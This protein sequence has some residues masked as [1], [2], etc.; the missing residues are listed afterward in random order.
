MSK[1]KVLP[2]HVA[3]K[4]AAGEVVDRPVNVVKELVENALDAGAT[5]VK[6]EI[7]DGGI[8]LIRVSDN[9]RGIEPEDLPLAVMRFATSKINNYEDLFKINTYG[10]RGEALAAISSVSNFNIKSG[11]FE[12]SVDFGKVGEVTPS[13][14]YDGTI[15][16]VKNIF[17]KIPARYKFLKSPVSEQKEIVKY[18]KQIALLNP[19]KSFKLISNEKILLEFSCN[20]TL[21]SKGKKIFG[22]DELVEVNYEEDGLRI[23]GLISLPNVQKFRK[24]NIFIGVNKRVVKDNMIAQSILQAYHRKI[25]ENRYPVASINIEVLPDSVD[26]NIHPAKMF[27]RFYNSNRI[28]KSI[29]KA[30]VE[31]LDFSKNSIDEKIEYSKEEILQT[32]YH[33]VSEYE[34]KYAVDLTKLIQIESIDDFQSEVSYSV[35]NED[36]LKILGQLFNTV[37]VV[38]KGDEV[39]FIDQHIAHERILYEKLIKKDNPINSVILTEPFLLEC[40][41]DEI[42]FVSEN[43]DKLMNCGI[44][45][46]IFGEKILKI[47]ALPA[48]ILNKNIEEEIRSIITSSNLNG[49]NDFIE[50]IYLNISCK[51]AIKAG[52]RLLMDEMKKLV[53]ELFECENPYT[54]PHGRPIIFKLNKNELFKKFH[55]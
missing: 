38:E 52:E 11:N 48:E 55:R 23:N 54:C 30:V 18:V 10:F 45:V 46:E 17:A 50:P 24:D 1:I 36:D 33:G 5:E 51:C 53:S 47:N 22:I 15:V 8:S 42:I 2:E 20:E 29:F 35:E 27:V 12:L 44:D 4:I 25:P 9:G 13:S 7:L 32:T 28:F 6:I 37:I 41:D 14:F 31:T 39:L 40:R 21:I 49:K 3:N 19:D 34:E 43:K 26:V 16:T